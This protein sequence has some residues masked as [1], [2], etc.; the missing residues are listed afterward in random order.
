MYNDFDTQIQKILEDTETAIIKGK[1]D[2]NKIMTVAMYKILVGAI[3]KFVETESENDPDFN[4]ALSYTW[5]SAGRMLKFVF[6]KA[7]EIATNIGGNGSACCVPDEVAYAWIREYYFADDKADVEKELKAEAEKKKKAENEKK[8]ETELK[9]KAIDILSKSA[10]WNTLSD[11]DKEKKIS[12]KVRN[13]KAAEKRKENKKTDKTAKTDT[14]TSVKADMT[15]SISDN[16][17]NNDTDI[18]ISSETTADITTDST[19]YTETVSNKPHF[20]MSSVDLEL[21]DGQMTLF[22]L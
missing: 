17:E 7:K 3:T 11:K 20:E 9:A 21:L 22:D 6:G 2:T 13:L 19:T 18:V 5:K 8:K 10:D 15:S 16:D 12:D 4:N 14:S 1:Q